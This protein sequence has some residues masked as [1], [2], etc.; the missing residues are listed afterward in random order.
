MDLVEVSR[1]RDFKICV[2]SATGLFH[3]E[4]LTGASSYAITDGR[5][6]FKGIK[7]FIDVLYREGLA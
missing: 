5:Y 3:G 6:T 2:D 1:Y 7:K 4:G